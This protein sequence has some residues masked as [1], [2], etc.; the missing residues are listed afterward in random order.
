MHLYLCAAIQLV[1]QAQG[2]GDIISLLSNPCCYLH[3]QRL[4]P[5]LVMQS[6]PTRTE[7]LATISIV[8]N[9][10]G[11]NLGYLQV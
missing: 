9:S 4:K 2:S 3:S 6:P 1:G 8:G 11:S 7:I 10:I 5:P